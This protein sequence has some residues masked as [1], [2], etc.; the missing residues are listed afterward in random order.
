MRRAAAF[1]AAFLFAGPA[2]AR[3]VKGDGNWI[4]RACYDRPKSDDLYRHDILGGTLEWSRLVV[5]LGAKGRSVTRDLAPY[6]GPESFA[7]VPGCRE[8]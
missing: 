4:T 8:G 1:V 7:D 6:A 5:T 3:C 2:F